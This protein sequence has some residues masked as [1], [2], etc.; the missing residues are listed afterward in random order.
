MTI[1]DAEVRE[2]GRLLTDVSAE[3]M[4]HLEEV[5][6]DLAQMERLR[7]TLAMQ[8]RELDGQLMRSVDQHHMESGD[9]T[10]F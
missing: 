2:L 1:Q 10:L 8:S 3:G 7:A 9:I 5:Q 6:A 4:S